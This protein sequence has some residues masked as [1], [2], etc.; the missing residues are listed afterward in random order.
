MLVRHETCARVWACEG[1]RHFMPRTYPGPPNAPLSLPSSGTRRGEP[2][3]LAADGVERRGA[4]TAL[5]TGSKRGVAL[6]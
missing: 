4:L 6:Q 5:Q 2:A 3:V 1:Q